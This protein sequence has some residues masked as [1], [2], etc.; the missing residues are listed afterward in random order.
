MTI[1]FKC[2]CGKALKAEDQHAGKRATCPGCGA[3]LIVPRPSVP[4]VVAVN[5]VEENPSASSHLRRPSE[6]PRTTHSQM[7]KPHRAGGRSLKCLFGFHNWGGCRCRTCG[8]E[9]EQETRLER[10]H[11]P[12]L[13]EDT[14]RRTRLERL[15]VYRVRPEERFRA[16]LGGMQ[17]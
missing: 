16:P 4:K 9:A 7:A 3:V 6:Q 5:A 17:V 12:N 14:R 15:R 1:K 2:N 11:M 13:R 10:M 8:R